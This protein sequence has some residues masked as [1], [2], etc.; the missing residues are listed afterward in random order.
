MAISTPNYIGVSPA[1]IEPFSTFGTT[2]LHPLGMRV[3]GR[4]AGSTAWG[5]GEFIYLVGVADTVAGDVVN[6]DEGFTTSRGVT[7]GV[8]QV[9]VAMSACVASNY[10]WYQIYGKAKVSAGAAVAD[11]AALFLCATAGSVDDAAV[12]GDVIYGARSASATDTGFIEAILS[13]PSTADSDVA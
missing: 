10:G 4:D 6:I 5:E 8:G 3:K 9:A 11:T 1:G 13:Y 2:Q 7:R 12:A